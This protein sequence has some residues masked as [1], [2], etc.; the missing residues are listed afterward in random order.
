MD[1]RGIFLSSFF[2]PGHGEGGGIGKRRRVRR[3]ARP[4]RTLPVVLMSEAPPSDGILLFALLH[5]IR[6]RGAETKI[7]P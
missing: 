1:L 4:L 2:P 6:S 7:F 3:C 5:P